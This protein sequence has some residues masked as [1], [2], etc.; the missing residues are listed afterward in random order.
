MKKFLKLLRELLQDND[1]LVFCP[2]LSYMEE[3]YGLTY[4]EELFFVDYQP[5][6]SN[7]FPNATIIRKGDAA[8]E[9]KNRK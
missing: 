1:V 8:Y 4:N 7:I 5:I 3:H 6:G 9:T 2:S